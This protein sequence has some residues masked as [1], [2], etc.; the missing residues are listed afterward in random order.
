MKAAGMLKL[1]RSRNLLDSLGLYY[2]TFQ[3]LSSQDDYVRLKNDVVCKENYLLF[4]TRVFSQ[5]KVGYDRYNTSHTIVKRPVGQ[6]RIVF[7]R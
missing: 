5:M 1:I 4:D 3:L 6:S 7:F 2:V